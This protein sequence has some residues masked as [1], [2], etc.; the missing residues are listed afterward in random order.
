MDEI[1]EKVKEI[2][3]KKRFDHVVRVVDMSLKLA[4]IYNSNIEKVMKSAYLH[5]IAKFFTL[6]EMLDLLDENEI[7]KEYVARE[8]LH[9]FAGAI[10]V[11]KE[12]KIDDEYLISKYNEVDNYI[13]LNNIL[14]NFKVYFEKKEKV[15]II[16]KIVYKL[17]ELNKI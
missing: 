2:L 15:S 13:I 17:K 4:K 3:P 7:E 12:F 6:E 14:D 5:D 1:I 10:Y 9:G 16:G 8:F 11:I